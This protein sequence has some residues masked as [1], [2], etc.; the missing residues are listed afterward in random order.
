M[1]LIIN[2]LT[3][4]TWLLACYFM[5]VRIEDGHCIKDVR[6][7]TAAAVC[8][9]LI[10]LVA[11]IQWMRYIDPEPIQGEVAL[12]YLGFIG[13][14][15]Y[16]LGDIRLG[17]AHIKKDKKV[18]YRKEG[19]ICFGIGHI[20]YIAAIIA[21]FDMTYVKYIVEV[22]IAALIVGLIAG[23][24]A[25]RLSLHFGRYTAMV[26]IYIGLLVF[27]ALL[28]FALVHSMD[29]AYETADAAYQA[30]IVTPEY[31]EA[32]AADPSATIYPPVMSVAYGTA[33]ALRAAFLAFV[34]SDI[35]L[36]PMYFGR[37][38]NKPHFVII[39]HVTYYIAQLLLAYALITF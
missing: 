36:A 7:K 34:V 16:A 8:I 18:A 4:A 1:A 27:A 39:N 22:F 32:V 26:S 3:L 25:R 38:G 10:G 23:F 30:T 28:A 6:L 11:D 33:K 19:I 17:Q 37:V 24:G 29:V 9:V 14:I 12:H 2:I 5:L 13:L 35:T 15:F 20:L 31:Q 21:L